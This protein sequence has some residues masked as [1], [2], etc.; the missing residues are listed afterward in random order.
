MRRAV[1]AD[2]LP[3][4]QSSVFQRLRRRILLLR[5]VV[6]R[7]TPSFAGHYSFDVARNSV[8]GYNRKSGFI[9]LKMAPPGGS[10]FVY[11]PRSAI[12]RRRRK[13]M[14]PMRRRRPAMMTRRRRPK[15]TNLIPRSD[16]VVIN[17]M[18]T[19]VYRIKR[20]KTDAF[21]GAA[22]DPFVGAN[23]YVVRT[24][25]QTPD[26][27]SIPQHAQY[28]ALFR[29]F[30]IYAIKYIFTLTTLEQTDNAIIPVMYLRYN[31]D[32][33]TTTASLNALGTAGLNTYFGSLTHCVK[34]TF[35]S[36]SNSVAYTV[37][38]KYPEAIQFTNGNFGARMKKAGWMD[39]DRV[40]TILMGLQVY[41]PNLPTGMR[42]QLDV[43]YDMAYRR[44]A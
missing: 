2:L 41:I 33:E 42:I 31:Y 27:I 37:W 32:E 22:P 36:T 10:P 38:P 20:Q 7:E 3:N 12:A 23:T 26:D 19:P 40:L 35:T 11:A 1:L 25:V 15:V 43:E 6:K 21:F 5:P 34:K 39:S 4:H 28:R 14:R 9:K 8:L 18:R 24:F 16:T 13:A 44:P 29:E 17:R 30:K